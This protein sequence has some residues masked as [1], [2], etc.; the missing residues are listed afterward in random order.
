MTADRQSDVVAQAPRLVDVS[1]KVVLELFEGL[2]HEGERDLSHSVFDLRVWG[3]CDCGT[4]GSFRTRPRL[5]GERPKSSASLSERRTVTSIPLA[6][7]PGWTVVDVTLAQPREIAFVEILDRPE[8]A[9]ELHRG[10]IAARS[11]E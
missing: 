7:L 3:M 5:R 1:E 10:L 8:I 11:R 6:V 9:D 4:C 2:R